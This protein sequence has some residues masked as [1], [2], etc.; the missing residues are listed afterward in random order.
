MDLSSNLMGIK[1]K[2]PLILSSGPM[3]RS[4]E[5]MVKALDAGAAAVVTETILNEIRP[6]VR[7]RMINKGNGLQNIRLYS[8][9]TLEEW[10]REI[11]IVKNSLLRLEPLMHSM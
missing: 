10:E 6:N 11:G 1:L 4:G 9:Y 5:M 2:N 7:P 3:S 8:D